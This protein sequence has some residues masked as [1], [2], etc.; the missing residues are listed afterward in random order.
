MVGAVG[1]VGATG[2]TGWGGAVGAVGIDATIAGAAAITVGL[3]EM[4]VTEA[5]A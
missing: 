4:V 1:A 2:A 5:E 3:V